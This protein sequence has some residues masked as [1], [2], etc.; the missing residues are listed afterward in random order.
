MIFRVSSIGA[1]YFGALLDGGL[2]ASGYQRWWHVI[3]VGSEGS[4]GRLDM[5]YDTKTHSIDTAE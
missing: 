2:A 3:G 1:V 4:C 5:F